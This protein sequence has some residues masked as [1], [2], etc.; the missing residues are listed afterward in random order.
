ADALMNGKL[1]EFVRTRRADG[2]PWRLIARE[3][4]VANTAIDVTDQTLR[5]WYPD[6]A[7]ETNGAVA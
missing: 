1:E 4:Y 2:V 7:D 6:P 3:L 5:K